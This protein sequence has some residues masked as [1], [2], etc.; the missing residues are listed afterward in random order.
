MRPFFGLDDFVGLGKIANLGN[1][2]AADTK[3]VVFSKT[4]TTT[5]HRLVVAKNATTTC[6]GEK[7]RL[8]AALVRV[9]T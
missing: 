4:E 2:T 7:E 1:V 6:S 8:E 3:T 5:S 9:E